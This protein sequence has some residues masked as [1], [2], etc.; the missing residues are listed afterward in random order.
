[1]CPILGKKNISEYQVE[2]L[3][4]SFEANPYPGIKE[5]LQLAKSLNMSQKE[6]EN[7]FGNIRGKKSKQGFMKI[8]C[9]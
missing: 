9:K 5:K 8:P 7:W 2:I 1:M 6:I 4:K 3:T